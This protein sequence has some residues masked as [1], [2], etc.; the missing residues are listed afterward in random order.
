VAHGWQYNGC[1]NTFHNGEGLLG[2]GN[3]NSKVILGWNIIME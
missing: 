2:C 1:P 3:D